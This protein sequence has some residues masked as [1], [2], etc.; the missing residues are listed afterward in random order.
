MDAM[1][2][3]HPAKPGHVAATLAV[4]HCADDS[5]P[6]SL[7]SVVA[8]AVSGDSIDL[9]HLICSRITLQLG[10]IEIE[11]DDIAFIGP[12]SGSLVIDGDGRDRVFFHAA[13]GTLSIS[14]VTIERGRHT[15]SGTDIGYGGCIATAGDLVLSSVVVR[16][17]H[18]T[19][20]GAYGG[21]VLSGFMTMSNSTISGNTAFGDHATNGTAAYG[22]GAFSYGVE[23]VDSTISDNRAIGTHNPPLS[24]WE[25]GGGLFIARNGGLIER[26]TIS[27]N[28]AMR[29]AGGLTQEGDLVLRNSTIS[30]N[31]ARDDDGGGLRVRSQTAVVV[32]NTTITNNQAGSTGGG[33]SFLDDTYPS[34][35]T[36]SIVAGNRAGSGITDIDG[37]MPQAISGSHNLVGSWG[38]SISLPG[39]T[40]TKPP[41]LLPLA[42]NG[43]PTLTHALAPDSPAI[44]EGSNPQQTP[45]DQRGPGHLREANA[46]ADIGA[47][48]LQGDAPPGQGATAVPVSSTLA[49]LLLGILLAGIGMRRA[50][51]DP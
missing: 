21:G 37:T 4:V 12:G 40:M 50:R 41:L 10:A 34:I 3:A 48:E 2:E 35:V 8:G 18:A 14:D 31:I 26:S 25:I 11:A 39:D 42:Y 28:Y 33:V 20:V 51:W 47:F 32:E 5:T 19:G 13:S 23:I 9:S 43:G 22:G 24:H 6:G 49:A 38:S 27:N 46:A 45:Y 17:C 1:R 16:D 44:D 36:S 29:F 30:G 7:R 15:A